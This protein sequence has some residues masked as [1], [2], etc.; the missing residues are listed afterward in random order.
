MAIGVKT[1][2]NKVITFAQIKKE[3]KKH[4]IE[5]KLNQQLMKI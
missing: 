5:I 4:S 2:Y 1:K 3:V